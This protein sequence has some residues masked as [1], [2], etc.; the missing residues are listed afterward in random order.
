MNF[1]LSSTKIVCTCKMFAHTEIPLLDLAPQIS[2]GPLWSP[3]LQR[4][5]ATVLIN[6][7]HECWG[8]EFLQGWSALS[9]LKFHNCS[10]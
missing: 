3:V 4:F 9:G 8:R 5:L 1:V 6:G 10:Q 2:L 7:I